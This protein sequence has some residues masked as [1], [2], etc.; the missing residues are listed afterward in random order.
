[1]RSIY[2]I[3]LRFRYSFTSHF[4]SVKKKFAPPLEK[5]NWRWLKVIRAIPPPMFS[6]L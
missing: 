2:E 3:K 5:Q 6:A 1:M 4:F